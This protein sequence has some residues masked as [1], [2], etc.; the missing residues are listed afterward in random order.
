MHWK[1]LGPIWKPAGDLGWARSHATCPTPWRLDQGTLR[2]FVQCRDADNVGRVGYV[3]VAADNPLE[4]IGTS[5][6]PV[7]DT[8]VPGTF[9]D[10]GVFQTCIV[11]MND[12]TLYLYYV[13]FELSRH[14]RYRLL[15]G[16]AISRDGGER[17]ERVRATPIL[18]RSNAE[19]YFRCGPFVLREGGRFRMW[20]I[21]GSQWTEIDGKPMPVYDMRYMESADGVRWP[22]QGAV[23]LQL[24]EPEEHGF[25]RPFVV[26]DGGRYKLYYS[27]RKRA[28]RQ[29]RLGYA[30]SPDG[31][32]W[33]RKDSEMN[34]DVSPSG[35]DSGSVE[36]SAVIQAKGNTYLFYNGNDFGA[37]GFGVARLEE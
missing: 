19:L 36:Y 12:S 28:L 14:I 32:H 26:N 11:P 22:E 30:E 33:V 34:I 7:L 15:T 3:D 20:Y 25:G 27:I 31:R 35:W 18:E 4:V 16:L 1:K 2:I 13:G 8:G 5:P 9:D 21:A 37:T 23:C 17:F 10:N 24:H 29:Y 6:L